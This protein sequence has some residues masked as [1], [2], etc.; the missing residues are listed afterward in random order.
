MVIRLIIKERKR[1]T[2]IL[3]SKGSSDREMLAFVN[4]SY[5]REIQLR[6][7][8]TV[9]LF[10]SGIGIAGLL[11]YAHQTLKEYYAQRTGCRRILLF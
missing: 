9:L 6:T 7:Y 3:A 8:S 10:A 2:T 11:L 4:S 1:F 5:G